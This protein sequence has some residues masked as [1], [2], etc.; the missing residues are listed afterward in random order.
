MDRGINGVFES[1]LSGVFGELCG[2][3]TILTFLW[4]G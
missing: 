4:L 1:V 3:D 2:S